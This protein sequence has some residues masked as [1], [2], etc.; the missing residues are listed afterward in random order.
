MLTRTS[1]REQR[2]C[3]GGTV[4]CGR[5]PVPIP[6]Q[7]SAVTGR[8]VFHVGSDLGPFAGGVIRISLPE[9]AAPPINRFEKHSVATRVGRTIGNAVLND[10]NIHTG[11]NRPSD[12][13]P[14][15]SID[16]LFH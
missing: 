9:Q 3:F 15:G 2:V 8:Y 11:S 14:H 7:E 12:T 6:S 4:D 10:M 5:A 13:F 16:D 1:Q